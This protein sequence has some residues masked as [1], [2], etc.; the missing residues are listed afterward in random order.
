MKIIRSNEVDPQL[1]PNGRVVLPL[2]DGLDIPGGADRVAILHAHHAKDFTEDRH[3]HAVMWEIFYFLQDADY[4][5][6]GQEYQINAGDLVILEPGDPHGALPVDH[7]V[8]I[9]VYQIP[10][11]DGDKHPW[12]EG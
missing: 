12:T 11:V 5:I 2:A 6:N 9:V 10:K 1:R 8:N 4:W 7:E 3:Y